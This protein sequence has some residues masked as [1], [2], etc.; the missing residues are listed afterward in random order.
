MARFYFFLAKKWKISEIIQ[1]HQGRFTFVALSPQTSPCRFAS[2]TNTSFRHSYIYSQT[3]AYSQ[4]QKFLPWGPPWIRIDGFSQP[5]YLLV[6][7]FRLRDDSLGRL[8]CTT[9]QF[10]ERKS[11]S[12][13]PKRITHD[14]MWI[15]WQRAFI[16]PF[17]CWTQTSAN[18]KLKAETTKLD[19]TWL[20]SYNKAQFR[21]FLISSKPVYN[22]CIEQFGDHLMWCIH[23][24]VFHWI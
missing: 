5:V 17:W 19:Q 11:M 21:V 20:A 8:Q 15:G 1:S 4:A 23:W 10:V 9:M 18:H 13:P 12:K 6:T 14:V 16:I 2:L 24:Q 22:Y 3:W 7:Q